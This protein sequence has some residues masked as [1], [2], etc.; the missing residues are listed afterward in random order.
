MAEQTLRALEFPELIK[1][2]QG[3]ASSALGRTRLA[4]IRPLSDPAQIAALLQEVTELGELT[5]VEGPCPLEPFPD[6]ATLRRR[7]QVPGSLLEPSDFNQILR[8]LR[9][10]S[11][12]RQYF[13]AVAGRYP[14]IARRALQLQELTPLRQAIQKAISPHSLIL[15]QA[16]PELQQLREEMACTRQ[17]LTRQIQNLFSQPEF[18]DVLQDR[19][20]AQ[21]H[22]RYVILLKAEC[23]GRVPGI[24]HDQS[25]SK[26]TL[27]VEPFEV[28]NLNNSLNL[29]VNEEKREQERIL[30]QL[31]DLVRAYQEA[32]QD[33]LAILAELDATNAKALYAQ[34]YRARAPILTRG[35]RASLR[36]ARH[37]LLL[38]R[39]QGRGGFETVVPVDL[40]L[41]PA[42]RFL[43]ISGANTGGKTVTLKTLGLLT[44]MVQCGIPIPVAEGSEI[45]IFDHIFADIGDTQDLASDLSTFSAHIKRAAAILS[46]IEG[47]C[48]VLLDELGTA[49]DPAEGGALA[50]ALL[51]A[52]A[53]AGAY[54]AVT[55]H[56]HL[57]KALAHEH[58]NL[59]N[60]A[61]LFDDQTQRP[62]YRLAYGVAGP[63]NALKIAGELGL[64][65]EIIAE[66]QQ[67]LGQEGVQALQ[68]LTQ[69][70]ASQQTLARQQQELM[71]KEQDLSA[72]LA[73]LES[74]RQAVAEERR[75]L[76]EENRQAVAR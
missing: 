36:T 8:V 30:R 1:V 17:Q 76:Q 27:F 54:G 24:I 45:C 3:Y 6:L 34:D 16:S 13:A 25:Q 2:L 61:V 18:R 73:D 74:Q 11:R 29:L 71:Q 49:T 68:L 48:L 5:V 37:P 53:R 70:E 66:A 59:V 39:E 44:L 12:V 75:Q 15:D 38:A 69:L 41:S 14:L 46:Q 43:V 55:T 10:V 42:R 28:I 50:L 20:V 64:A 9:L 7:V 32:I 35:G 19:L 58:P 56:F 62:L 23:K 26:A 67:Y 63:S 4:Q 52:L 51:N 60:A 65:P 72:Q 22:G 47:R 57:L 31:T 33:N 40:E 21:R